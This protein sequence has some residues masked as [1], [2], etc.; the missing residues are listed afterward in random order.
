MPEFSSE[1]SKAPRRDNTP[2]LRLSVSIRISDKIFIRKYSNTEDHTSMP[3]P[4]L[5]FLRIFIRISVWKRIRGPAQGRRPTPRLHTNADTSDFS[6]EFSLEFSKSY[7]RQKDG[8]R[9]RKRRGLT[10]RHPHSLEFLSEF[11]KENL[12][13]DENGESSGTAVSSS[14]YSFECSEDDQKSRRLNIPMKKNPKKPRR[15]P[16][17]RLYANDFSFE[18]SYEIS[19][20][21]K[22]AKKKQKMI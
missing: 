13:P 7:G 8:G 4:R 12:I 21:R 18:Y 11:S 2:M 10:R 22:Q 1:F 3:L 14:E 5:S 17:P 16:T 20:D 9:H 19:I 6:L 15:R